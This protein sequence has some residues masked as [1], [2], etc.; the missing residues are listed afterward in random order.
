MH[1]FDRQDIE[2]DRQTAFSSLDRVCTSCSAVK[3]DILC[4]TVSM[5]SQIIVQILDVN[6]SLCVFEPPLARGR[7][8]GQ[9]TL[10]MLG[11]LESSQCM[12]FVSLFV[13][14]AEVLRAN[15]D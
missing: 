10:F 7:A 2:A 1:A 15:N 12:D 9:R 5:L 3:T 6:R 13:Y 14:T 8:Y 4:H 11:S